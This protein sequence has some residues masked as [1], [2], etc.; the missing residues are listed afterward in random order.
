MQITSTWLRK[1]F[2]PLYWPFCFVELSWQYPKEI[3]VRQKHCFVKFGGIWCGSISVVSYFTAAVYNLVVAHFP[4]PRPTLRGA[5]IHATPYPWVADKIVVNL[6]LKVI[7]P[8]FHKLFCFSL[9]Y[10]YPQKRP[11][12]KGLGTTAFQPLINTLYFSSVKQSKGQE[13]LLRFYGRLGRYILNG[14][15]WNGK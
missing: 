10:F 2:V 14:Y 1:A 5:S 12:R 7:N 3:R 11:I 15:N 4:R 6:Y 8:Q 9:K 13:C